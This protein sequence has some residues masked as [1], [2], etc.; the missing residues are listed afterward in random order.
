MR[1]SYGQD[2]ESILSESCGVPIEPGDYI[3]NVK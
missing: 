1:I 2:R 3:V